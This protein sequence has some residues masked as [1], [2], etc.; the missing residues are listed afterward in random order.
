[1]SF[2]KWL[3]TGVSVRDIETLVLEFQKLNRV[4]FKEMQDQLDTL[5]IKTLE[6]KRTYSKKLKKLTSEEKEEEVIP[7]KKVI[8]EDGLDDLR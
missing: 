2:W 8:Y 1:M 5:E 6:A 7:T 4:R 3:T